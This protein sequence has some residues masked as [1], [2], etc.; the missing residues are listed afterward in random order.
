MGCIEIG[1]GRTATGSGPGLIE[2]WDVLKSFTSER[3]PCVQGIN[4]NMG[5][6]EINF[7]AIPPNGPRRI[8]RNMGCIEI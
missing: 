3:V 2:T 7:P 4:R 8:N 1:G 6:I 5:C